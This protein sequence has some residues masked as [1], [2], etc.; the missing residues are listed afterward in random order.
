MKLA[1]VHLS[2]RLI[3]VVQHLDCLVFIKD[4]FVFEINVIFFAELESVVLADGEDLPVLGEIE[5]MLKT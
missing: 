3:P 5:S 4:F 2:H 1:S